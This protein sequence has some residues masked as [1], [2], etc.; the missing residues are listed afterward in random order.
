MNE[1]QHGWINA[2]LDSLAEV[3]AGQAA[4]QGSDYF[5]SEGHP[6]VRAGSLEFL[7]RGGNEC[8]LEHIH[9]SAAKS[10][11]LR[12]FPPNTI[13]FA[14]SGMSATKGLIYRIKQPCYVVS[15]LAALVPRD[16]LA[17][18]YLSRWLEAHPPTALISNSAYPSIRLSQVASV[19]IQLPK[20]VNEQHRIAAILDKADAILR[21]RRET[22]RLLDD[23]LRSVFLDMFDDPV[24]NPKGWTIMKFRDLGTSRLGKMLDK[25]KQLGNCQ[26]PYLA[27]CNVQWGCF[28]LRDLRTM[29]FSE[30]DRKEFELRHG[31]LLICEGGEVGRSAIWRC[32]R[33][34]VY[35]QKALHRVRLDPAISMPEYVMHHMWFMA[36]YNKFSD[37]T[38][39]ATIAHLTGVQL[40][41]LPIPVPPIFLQY[42][43]ACIV[44]AIEKQKEKL[45]SH[46]AESETLLSSLQSHAFKGKLS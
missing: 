27:N 2:T 37:L 43:F 42:R 4:P 10:H 45:H 41:E 21:K 28:D 38:N 12:L 11:G 5:G 19:S 14:K 32:Q 9:D 23:F 20:D 8:E 36:K 34:G 17:P 7:T 6:F 35:F 3:A 40:R 31:D 1:R 15:H 25:G 39:S 16:A 24:T 18:E 22:I 33:H 44:K 29:D 13:L 30:D 46:A 26:F